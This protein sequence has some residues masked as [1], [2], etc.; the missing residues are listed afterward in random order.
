MKEVYGDLW[1]LVEADPKSVVCITTNGFVKRNGC[2]VMGRGCARQ[3]ATKWP[4]LPELLGTA[5]QRTGNIVR[6]I[7]PS[8]I[9]GSLVVTFPVK[10]NWWEAADPALITRSMRALGSIAD[11]RPEHNFYLPRPG[12]GNGRLKWGDVK[13]LLYPLPDNVF[14]VTWRE[15]SNGTAKTLEP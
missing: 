4:K 9:P 14:I 5:I 10:H 11:E 7:T 3:A 8:Q 12:C 15:N 2:A 1:E 6:C 13:S